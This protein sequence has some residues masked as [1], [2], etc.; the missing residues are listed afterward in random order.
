M[1]LNYIFLHPSPCFCTQTLSKYRRCNIAV[2]DCNSPFYFIRMTKCLQTVRHTNKHGG[3]EGECVLIVQN[4][5]V[6]SIS[7]RTIDTNYP[8]LTL[9]FL[10]MDRRVCLQASVYRP[11]CLHST[12]SRNQTRVRGSR[13]LSTPK[14]T[15]LK[16]IIIQKTSF[17][18]VGYFR[19]SQRSTLR[20]RYYG[21]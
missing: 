16:I 13:P 20:S 21:F 17:H 19:F 1:G 14:P 5:V 15:R 12:D 3:V 18:C 7:A 9:L 6:L 11:V 2:R 10:S 4:G 8:P